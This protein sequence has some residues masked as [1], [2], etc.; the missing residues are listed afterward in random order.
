M[1]NFLANLTAKNSGQA[2][3]LKPRLP[4]LFEPWPNDVKS[5]ELNL[6]DSNEIPIFSDETMQ[7]EGELIQDVGEKKAF[8]TRSKPNNKKAFKENH[9]EYKML[10]TNNDEIRQANF[11]T[12]N[13]ET[14]TE[15]F[16]LAIKKDLGGTKSIAEQLLLN[17]KTPAPQQLKPEDNQGNVHIGTKLI[18]ATEKHRI[19]ASD[20]AKPPQYEQNK[21]ESKESLPFVNTDQT[22]SRQNSQL[23][24][25]TKSQNSQSKVTGQLESDSK[26]NT[27]PSIIGRINFFQDTGAIPTLNKNKA[28]SFIE[29][30]PPTVN[31]TIGRIE[32]RAI[33]HAQPQS[34]PKPAPKTMSLDDYLRQ[35]SG[36]KS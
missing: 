19:Q 31:V 9:E 36:G 26:N 29:N 8:S 22:Q 35:R 2:D 25:I 1:N 3:V 16:N 24:P 11:T 15:A 21:N 27:A 23:I 7:T 32:V 12:E 30:N 33:T 34:K 20:F 28:E 10:S 18:T 5:L 13:T 4:S 6:P 14:Y 17:N